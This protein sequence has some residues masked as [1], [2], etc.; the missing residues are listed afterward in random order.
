MDFQYNQ[1][2]AARL[3]KLTRVVDNILR[4]DLKGFGITENQITILFVLSKKGKMEQGKLGKHL[5]LERSSISRNI[6]ILLDKGYIIKSKAFRP[7][8]E[9]TRKGFDNVSK[10]TPIWNEFMNKWYD[11]IG[12]DGM[13][14]LN[15]LEQK[16]L[17]N[18]SLSPFNK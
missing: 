18:Q 15:K 2:I 4:S 10:F 16:I 1:C 5:G 12:E 7:E 6:Q 13:E 14:Y 8:I 9:L 3:R 17:N 11:I